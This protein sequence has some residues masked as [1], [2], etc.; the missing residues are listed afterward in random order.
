MSAGAVYSEVDFSAPFIFQ[1]NPAL[2]NAKVN[3]DMETDGW[4]PSFEFGTLYQPGN[5]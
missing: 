5:Q 3:L 4:N 1:T 2:A